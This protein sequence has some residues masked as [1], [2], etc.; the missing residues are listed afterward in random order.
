M[1]W[2]T[3]VIFTITNRRDL[4]QRSHNE[5][6]FYEEE[7][8]DLIRQW[9]RPGSVFCDIGANIGNHAL[10]ALKFLHVA[11][12]IAFE[13]NPL[14]IG[15][16]RSNLIL[17][18]VADRADLSHLGIGL[19][20]SDAGGFT[21][22]APAGNL[23]G[24]RMIEGTGDLP[25]RRGDALLADERVDFIKIDV[26]GMELRVLDGLSATIAAHRPRLFVEVDR[27]NFRG[28]EAWRD[29]NGYILRARFRRYRTCENFMVTHRDDAGPASVWRPGAT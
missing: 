26:E 11:R 4:I 17:N 12:L 15:V 10:F 8:L 18:G 22:N 23:G 21:I 9:C 13:P 16:L 7:E 27:R 19:S 25:V 14:A 6:R 3:P 29:A 28:F 24:G 2:D 1:I 20:D 5:G